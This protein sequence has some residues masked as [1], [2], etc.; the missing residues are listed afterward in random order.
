MGA[1]LAAKLAG[2]AFAAKL[3]MCD[4]TGIGHRWRKTA[5]L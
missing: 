3:K 1:H 4:G 5:R 2:K